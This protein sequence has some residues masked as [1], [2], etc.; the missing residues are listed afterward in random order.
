LIDNPKINKELVATFFFEHAKEISA[1]IV[2][3]FKE[4]NNKE[5]STEDEYYFMKRESL[6]F[7]SKILSNQ[8]FEKFY[9]IYT[10]DVDNLKMIMTQLNNKSNKILVLAIDLLNFFFLDIENKDKNI[11]KILHSNKQNFYKFFSTVEEI[12]AKD[13]AFMSESSELEEKKTFILYELER[14]ENYLNE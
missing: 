5:K 1:L 10:N 14:L 13:P 11:K 8:I 9:S 6:I 3:S 7:I 12:I 4:S 2:K